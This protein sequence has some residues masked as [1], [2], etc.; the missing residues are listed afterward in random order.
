MRIVE[1]RRYILC[2]NRLMQRRRV[3]VRTLGYIDAER[4]I[5]D[6]NRQWM[7]PSTQRSRRRLLAEIRGWYDKELKKID[8]V[9]EHLDQPATPVGTNLRNETR[10]RLSESRRWRLG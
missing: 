1:N 4:K 7:S 2:R 5:V 8:R 10:N 6:S 9:I 3:V